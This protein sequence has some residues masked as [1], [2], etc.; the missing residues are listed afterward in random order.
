MNVGDDRDQVDVGFASFRQQFANGPQRRRLGYSL[1][2][3]D[4]VR[5]VND[6]ERIAD[7][8]GAWRAAT[9]KPP[10]EERPPSPRL[11]SRLFAFTRPGDHGRS[12]GR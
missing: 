9:G 7:E 11:L 12:S 10:C 1:S 8:Y 6:A 4:A 3:E 2:H 5:I